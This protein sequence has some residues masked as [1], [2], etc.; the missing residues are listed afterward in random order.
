MHEHQKKSIWGLFKTIESSTEAEETKLITEDNHDLRATVAKMTPARVH[1]AVL[2]VS[3][4]MFVL[5]TLMVASTLNY[6][7]S[8]R[9]CA[10][11]L[12]IWCKSKY[13]IV[14]ARY[15]N[16]ISPIAPLFEAVEYE[17][18]D[19]ESIFTEKHSDWTGAPTVELEGRWH[20]L[21]NGVCYPSV[22]LHSQ[23]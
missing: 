18:R 11:Q 9:S 1:L 19:W 17:E 14:N 3:M 10:A 7:Q 22:T 16:S 21:V 2:L 12:S 6:K 8:D 13:S 20:R 23:L 4:F 15:P 5:G